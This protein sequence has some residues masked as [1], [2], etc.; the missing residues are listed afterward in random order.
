MVTLDQPSVEER[1]WS[2]ACLSAVGQGGGNVRPVIGLSAVLAALLLLV[3]QSAAPPAEAARVPP[4]PV[5][6]NAKCPAPYTEFKIEAA[7]CPNR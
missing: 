4:R 3:A 6:F 1:G 7:T 2:P 5:D